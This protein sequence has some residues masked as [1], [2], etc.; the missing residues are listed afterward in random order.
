MLMFGYDTCLLI[1]NQCSTF[2]LPFQSGLT[3]IG[4]KEASPSPDIGKVVYACM[5]V[6]MY[7]CMYA[8]MYVCMYV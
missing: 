4:A 8:C 1:V 7:V 3:T 5:Y 6:C 2:C